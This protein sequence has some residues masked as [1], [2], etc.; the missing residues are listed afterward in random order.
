MRCRKLH[1]F[2]ALCAA[3]A[4]LHLTAAAVSEEAP[5]KVQVDL[6]METLCP[7]CA[8]FVHKQLGDLYESDGFAD[9]MQLRVIPWGNA[10]NDTGSPVCQHGAVE[11]EMNTVLSCVTAL[12]PDQAD[13]FP[14]AWCTEG[15]S[16]LSI[17]ATAERCARGSGL[18]WDKIQ[19]CAAGDM[20][21]RLQREAAAATAAL[22]P[23]HQ[24][25]P[26]VVVN[27]VPILDDA[28]NVKQY[29]CVAYSG[30]RPPACFDPPVTLSAGR[31]AAALRRGL[32]SWGV[33]GVVV[34][35]V[36]LAC[37]QMRA[38]AM[39]GQRWFR[40]AREGSVCAK[41]SSVEA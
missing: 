18:D 9:I 6:Y 26:W 16:A 35:G 32:Q 36:L 29:I 14:F 15:A 8:R 4:V 21:A 20:G 25:V 17:A 31:G 28:A 3:M 27:G 5:A 37:L 23:A 34:A 12:H 39:W 41:I 11:C 7:Y 10:H 40:D 2:A 13:W 22:R 30:K 1:M 24:W 19:A 33:Q 38:T